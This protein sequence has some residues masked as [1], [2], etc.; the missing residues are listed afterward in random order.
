VFERVYGAIYGSQIAGLRELAKRGGKIST[1]AAVK[2]FDEA[3]SRSAFPTNITFDLWL[4]FLKVLELIEA[5]ANEIR[6]SDKGKDF[7]MYLPA[8]GL[9]E[10]KPN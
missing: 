5:D 7:L 3:K 1:V 8:K 4:Q 9:P 10:N 2:V 6:M